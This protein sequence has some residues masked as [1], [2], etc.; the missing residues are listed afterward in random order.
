MQ[1]GCPAQLKR[2]E[3][4]GSSLLGDASAA[5]EQCP[6]LLPPLNGRLNKQDTMAFTGETL[7]EALGVW[8][9]ML[10]FVLYSI[11][12]VVAMRGRVWIFPEGC[13]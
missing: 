9:E 7:P 11:L 10:H 5:P 3:S 6:P 8:S 13:G 12:S 1:V 2:L 4:W